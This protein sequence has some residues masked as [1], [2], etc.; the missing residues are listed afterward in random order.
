MP[1]PLT[2][3]LA[4]LTAD[5]PGVGGVIKE[6][7]EDFLVE[8]LPAYQPSG[9]GEHLFLYIE[10]RQQTTSDVIRRI[11]RAWNV[12][13]GDIGYAGL[14]DKQAVTRQ[15]LSIRLPDPSRD[16]ELLA[17]LADT[18]VKVLWAQRHVN[19]IRRGH[20]A[21][22]RFVIRIRQV[23]PTAVI[24]TKQ[25]L[26][27][28]AQQG[29]PNFVGDQRFGFR[30]TNHLAGRALLLGRWQEALDLALANPDP[31]ESEP[32]REGRL[33]Y[34]RGDYAKALEHWP[35]NLHADRQAL[36]LL[37]QGRPVEKVVLSLDPIQREFLLNAW[38]SHVFNRVLDRRLRGDGVPRF[39]HLAQGDLAYKHDNGAVF[40]VDA[41]TASLENGPDGRV[42]N[43][44][45]SP[46]GPM[47]GPRMA[48]AAG[49]P[50]ELE[51]AELQAFGVTIDELT[52][53]RPLRLEGSRR[54]LRIPIK[55]PDCS[56]GV[57]EFGPYIRVAFELPKGS[58]ATVVLREI[59]KPHLTGASLP[60]EQDAS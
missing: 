52:Q 22:N 24:R 54:S 16:A 18:P 23:E 48:R 44:G 38:Q 26:D 8:E 39:D 28:L 57:D 46:S 35:R 50:D 2:A 31:D 56:G 29:V 60:E 40:L 15:H 25:V 19:K 49:L 4:C 14:K 27:R 34:Q 17:R 41:D 58:Y 55:D 5:V 53:P 12:D 7:P 6:R 3:D 32:L 10:K 30:Q 43:L 51:V 1:R 13:R 20:L 37:R 45:L 59:M 33:A 47:W 36:D 21:G 11:T 42:R 9:Q